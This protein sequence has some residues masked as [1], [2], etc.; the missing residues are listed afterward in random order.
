VSRHRLAVPAALVG[1]VGLVLSWV[2]FAGLVLPVVAVGL[3][4]AGLGQAQGVDP[5]TPEGLRSRRAAV[6]GVVLGALGVLVAVTATVV[7]VV[8]WPSVRG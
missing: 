2:P 1:A 6:M 5:R 7:F 3:G 8:V 4:A